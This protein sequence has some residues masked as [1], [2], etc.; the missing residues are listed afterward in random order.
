MKIE[1]SEKKQFKKKLIYLITYLEVIYIK[2][3]GYPTLTAD[4]F[5]IKKVSITEP[6]KKGD[7][8]ISYIQ[9]DKNLF[10]MQTEEGGRTPFGVK[11]FAGEKSG[12]N[13]DYNLNVSLNSTGELVK[14]LHQLDEAM[15]DFG[16]E[17]SKTIL[18]QKYS[19]AQREVVRALYTSCVKVADE[20]DYPPR[21][22]LKIQRKSVD[23]PVPRIL[24]FHSETEE[25]EIESF[26]Q[27][28]RLIPKGSS[29]KALFTMKPWFISGK[30]G[31]TMILEQIIV[32][33]QSGGRPTSYAFNDKTGA[34]AT[35]IP[36]AKA[37]ADVVEEDDDIEEVE[38]DADAE[39]KENSDAVDSE[40]EEEEEEEDVQVKKNVKKAVVQTPAPAVVKKK[41]TVARK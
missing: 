8:W 9:H 35:V 28:V 40:A 39:S 13:N 2:M 20:G 32:S 1:H 33:K 22:T 21:I 4:T 5:D 29:V 6:K 26:E 27:L 38:A 3:S 19:A 30:F 15:L 10:L 14:K 11:S 18:K 12:E 34:I 24:F 16:I 41:P 23:N 7:R 31:I 25:V 36:A 37:V 17:H